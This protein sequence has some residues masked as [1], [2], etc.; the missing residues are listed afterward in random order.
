M[1]ETRKL[2]AI[3]VADVVGYSRPRQRHEE[4]ANIKNFHAPMLLPG[5][6]I[7]TSPDY[8]SPIRQLQLTRFNPLQNHDSEKEMRG[9]ESNLADATRLPNRLCAGQDAVMQ[10][11]RATRLGR[12]RP[13]SRL[14]RFTR[15]EA[16][17]AERETA[18]R[19]RRTFAPIALHPRAARIWCLE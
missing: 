10:I 18:R 13:E 9:N 19:S 4:A 17:Q 3:L 7:N 15:G 1:S 16:G 11:A 12:E 8:Y 2:A 14:A 5:V 6:T